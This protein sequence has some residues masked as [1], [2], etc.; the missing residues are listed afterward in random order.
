MKLLKLNGF[1]VLLLL[2][3]AC[4][5]DD[6][7]PAS[8]KAGG[9]TT[10]VINAV[11]ADAPTAPAVAPGGNSGKTDAASPDAST[12]DAMPPETEP[13]TQPETEQ[14]DT[15]QQSSAPQSVKFNKQ[16]VLKDF[17]GKS[18][19]VLDISERSFDG[20][21]AL[22]VTLSVPLDPAENH[23]DYFSVS[24]VNGANVNGAWVISESG[25][26]AY[27]PSAEPSTQYVV[28]VY[29]GLTAANGEK[30]KQS[31][32]EQ[33]NT[34]EIKPGY[35]FASEG[36]FLPLEHHSGLPVVV[37][38][39]PEVN[40]DYF[41]VKADRITQFL[42]ASGSFR[43]QVARY[44]TRRSLSEA[45]LVHSARY[46]F[47]APKNKRREFN[48]PVQSIDP[49]KG[50]GVYV[51]VMTLPGEYYHDVRMT[52]FTVTDIG[53]HVR[54][55][56]NQI[57]SY[58]TSLNSGQPLKGI[59]VSIV[60][61]KGTTLESTKS[62]PEGLASFDQSAQNNTYL[63]A[64]T[65][66]SVSIV[67]FTGPALDLSDFELANRP[68]KP[69]ELFVYG[70]RDLY[71]PGETVIFNG[72][73]RDQDGRSV[74]TPALKS[75]IKRPDGQVAH[76]F[77]WHESQMGFY[78]KTFTLPQDAKTGDWTLE[79]HNV[80]KSP[81]VYNFKVE[82]FLPE[83]MKITF[84]PG[85]DKRFYNAREKLSVKVLGEYLYGAP[86]NGN[87]FTSRVNV[88]LN[89]KP[90][91]NLKDFQFGNI[92]ETQL[93]SNFQLPDIKL[94]KNGEADI[95]IENRWAAAKSPVS[96]ALLGSLYESGGRPVTR[97]HVTTIW[98]ESE[99]IGI[100]PHFKKNP[101][102]NSRVSFDL[103]K[104]NAKGE[105]LAARDLEV[106]LVRED[107]RYFWEYN[108]S[109]G[110]HYQWSD[111]E[112]PEYTTSVSLKKGE[113]TK[114]ELSVEYGSY[115][116]EV[117]DPKTQSISSTRFYA[118]FDWYYWW[119]H[120]ESGAQAARPDK[121]ALAL[122]K[123]SYLEGES[124]VLSIVPPAA[125][126]AIVLVESDKPLFMQRVSV[127]AKGMKV[128]I[129]IEKS[130]NR[131][132]LYISVVHL[133]KTDGK[134][135]ITPTRSF[136][137][138]HLPLNRE[139]RKLNISFDVAE[140]IYPNQKY[141]ANLKVDGASGNKARLTLSMVDVGVLSI[142]DF[143]T[144]DPHKFFF[145]PRRYQVDSRDMYSDL[146]ELND[147]PLARQ[148]FGGDAEL[149]RGG[150][151]A[152][153][154]V[155][156][157]ALFS[158]LVEVDSNGNAKVEFE[159]PDFNGRVRF[160]AHAFTQDSVGSAEQEMTIAA[161]LVTQIAMPRFLAMG[162]QSTFALDIH[163]LTEEKQTLKVA[164]G[165]NGPVSL[166]NEDSKMTREFTQDISL[167]KNQKTTLLYPVEV[168][169]FI[170]RSQVDLNIEGMQGYPVN[171]SWGIQ[172]R[173]AYP[174]IIENK[175]AVLKSGETLSLE[176]SDLEKFIP[177]SVEAVLS[178]SNAVDLK[179]REQMDQ[180]LRYPYGCLEQTTSSTYP[181][182]FATDV[183][184]QKMGLKNKTSKS[185]LQSIEYG[186]GRIQSK[187][188]NTGGYG[189]WNNTSS[190]QHW[191]T[192]YVGDFL[193]DA[194]EQGIK[195]SNSFYDKTMKRLDDYLRNRNGNYGSRWSAHP[196]H[197]DFAYRAY[198]AYVLSRHNK[199]HLSSLRN[200]AS[201][202]VN[203]SQSFLPLVHLGLALI[204]QGDEVQGSEILDKAITTQRG[205]QYYADYGSNIRDMALTIH[206]LLRHQQEMDHA[207]LLAV[208]LADKIK[209]RRYLSTQERNSIFLAGIALE[210]KFSKEW[211]ADLKLKGV[212]ETIKK[213]GSYAQKYE[214]DNLQQG[215]SLT[216]QG[217]SDLF[218]EIDYLGHSTSAPQPESSKNLS[219][220]RDYYDTK[221]QPL[222]PSQLK[223][224]DLVLVGLRIGSEWR[225][226][227]VL[228]VD[229]LPAGLELENQNLN[230]AIKLDE[231][232]FDGHPVKY[233]MDRTKVVHKEYRDDRFVA[234]IDAGYGYSS[235]LFYLARAVTPGTYKVPA[236]LVED[237]YRPE[238]RAIGRTI[239]S[240]QVTNPD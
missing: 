190:E 145:E 160:M 127:P 95:V 209:Q 174:A 121:V 21:N 25:K 166:K 235:H 194:R 220:Q 63:I 114:L 117:K 185:R 156:I 2:V 128:S 94:D 31:S 46:R 71:R 161:P 32:S 212:I 102:Q 58:L 28:K 29:K 234:A 109:R 96:V 43:D 1:A 93:K 75:K 221:G 44:Y 60:D 42:S 200:L 142:T 211:Q 106:T 179:L 26:I 158:G 148:R 111:K 225:A 177:E 37:V 198:A 115:R 140:R 78:T 69:Q 152:Q 165:I 73:L 120:N 193:T 104:A 206:L 108:T 223:V 103:V 135:R 175:K 134:N 11:P 38:N 208:E 123:A 130:W 196:G 113:A 110:W 9:N 88:N 36:R 187:M 168:G 153:A 222:D 13:D 3:T 233:W 155:Q 171:R 172:V 56:D 203:N 132:D 124:A 77:S 12:T 89:R 92:K 162:D 181:W 10:E 137:L 139:S 143:E 15:Q 90:L 217:E 35:S 150:K 219:I 141:T 54:V 19:D 197:Y 107:R 207:Q 39:T 240:I 146:I 230:H 105:M 4:S 216:N 50:P 80:G 192:A 131:H 74:A 67:P 183:N 186:L 176:Q 100:R 99:M 47:D 218:A 6:N 79:V 97:R 157:V 22:A 205:D 228:V 34:R 82:E 14:E 229:L 55:Y 163:N 202:K 201:H 189:L 236:P 62:T 33:V 98:P 195:V 149:S 118:G 81:V 178:V 215:L 48:L 125:G 45:D 213:N 68:Y 227:D 169:Y 173:A 144:P 51:A 119:K 20:G 170:G 8:S 237:M 84:N 101:K 83:R 30:L 66:K 23:D 85:K 61:H 133:Q 40:V 238:D 224:G 204:N 91:E 65:D 151:N 154:E 49:L 129:P 64:R 18:V 27:F 122:D 86:A 5:N 17:A 199:A 72:L 136:G 87:R 184:L 231:I 214:A 182:L 147:K 210:T 232:Q 70:P 116:L 226:P 59:S 138:I 112:Y 16:Q 159:I 24:I 7:Q 239:D 53:M 180:L 191:L 188:L 41:K 76:D 126:E 167:D 52:Y 57:D 164:L